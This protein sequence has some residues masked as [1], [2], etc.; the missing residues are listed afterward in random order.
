MRI[1]TWNVNSLK[2]RLPR[3][4][5]W[6]ADVQPDVLCMQETKLSDD[7][8]PALTFAAMGYDAVHRGQGQWNGVAILSKVGLDQIVSNF[9]EGEPDPEA[10]IVTALCG[11]MRV[12]SVYVPNGRSLDDDHY[13]YKLRWMAQLRGH[14]AAISSPDE[15]VVVA[16]DFNIA[17]ADIDVYDPA[18]FVGATHTSEP[19][20]GLLA[21]LCQWG[22]VD[23]FRQHHSEGKLYSWWDYRA[24][25][26]HEGRGLR[27]DLVLGTSAVADRCTWSVIDRN[28]RK[29]QSPSDHAPVIV[30]LD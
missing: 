12:S 20:R 30:E 26:F 8:F 4:E 18:K 16:G 15:A 6:L 13:Q 23:L 1:A 7:A 14:V 11:G 22:M 2:V 17:P 25:D 27:I 5:Q 3:V 9:A 21:D 19:E 28:A 29:G 10:R 24:G